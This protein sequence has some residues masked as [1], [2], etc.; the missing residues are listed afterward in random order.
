MIESK[1]LSEKRIAEILSFKD[2]DNKGYP[3]F[4][5][6]QLAQ[7]KPANYR[8]NPVKKGIFIKIDADVLE[9]LKEEGKGYQTRIN[10]ILRKA[11]F[12]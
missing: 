12:G 1:K 7:F 5:E 4:T 9:A 11:V 6:E 8:I 3:E 2:A 10:A